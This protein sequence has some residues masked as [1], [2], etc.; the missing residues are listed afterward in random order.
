MN[1]GQRRRA[2]RTALQYCL[3]FL[4]IAAV[5]EMAAVYMHAPLILPL[6]GTV[7]TAFVRLCSRSIFWR[8]IGATF[9]RCFYSFFISLAVGSLAG[10]LCGLSA[11]FRNFMALPLSVIRSTP[12]VSFILL[13]LF[14]FDSS[15]VPVFVA[16]LMTLPVMV[17]SVSSGF[18]KIDARMSAMASLYGF[19]AGQRFRWITLPAVMPFF[20]SGAVSCFG[21][22]WKVVAAG[23]VLSLPRLGAGTLLQTAQ[24][25]LETDEVL[26]ITFVIVILSFGLEHLLAYAVSR[27]AGGQ[28]S[29]A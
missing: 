12:V 21:L 11:S 29:A 4:G 13:A 10:I 25:H 26:A 20:L 9:L 16:V 7:F 27:M 1:S 18:S 22:S 6:P 8:N 5:W 14:W 23:E 28:E 3:S 17:T 2:V 15:T 19:T 24:V